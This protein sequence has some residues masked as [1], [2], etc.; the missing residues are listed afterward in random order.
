MRGELDKLK[1]LLALIFIFQGMSISVIQDPLLKSYPWMRLVGVILMISGILYIYFYY[2]TVSVSKLEKEKSQIKSIEDLQDSKRVGVKKLKGELKRKPS[3]EVEEEKSL[4]NKIMGSTSQNL[5]KISPFILPIIGA[6]IIDA[7]LIYNILIYKSL[8]LRGFD[9]IT[10]TFGLSLIFYNYIPKKF[11]FAKDFLVF[12]LGLLFFIL[13]F[14]PIFYNLLFGSGG[15]AAVTKTFLGD[16]V[17]WLLNLGG[18]KSSCAVTPDPIRGEIATVYFVLAQSGEEATV[19]IAEACSGI[20]TVSIFL[21]AFITFILLEYKRFDKKVALLIGL[22]I[23]TAYIANLF[24]MTIII[25]IGHFYDSD[26]NNLQN[27]AWAHINAG[28]LIFLAWIIP[29]WWLMYRFLMKK[30]IYNKD[31]ESSN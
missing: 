14:P 30:D 11:S 7:V 26:P 3:I 6:I 20:Y 28:W 17:T 12:F 2:Q 5:T 19:S 27:L 10:I 1:I 21:S 23:F 22:G 18:V 4:L 9:S 16:P 24:R 8:D 15:D 13:I 25:L 29:F 31:A